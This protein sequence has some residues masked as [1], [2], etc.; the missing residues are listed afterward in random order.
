MLQC[1]WKGAC[2]RVTPAPADGLPSLAELVKQRLQYLQQAGHLGQVSAAL[3]E[4]AD[5]GVAI[6]PAEAAKL[7]ARGAER[8]LGPLPAQEQPLHPTSEPGQ[9]SGCPR[10]SPGGRIHRT[11][12]DD[13]GGWASMLSSFDAQRAGLLETLGAVVD[14]CLPS[15]HA[16]A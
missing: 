14:R 1:T 12:A 16:H 13:G 3:V 9:G 5:P 4:C 15:N 6:E 8:I 7:R 2:V 11:G 10:G